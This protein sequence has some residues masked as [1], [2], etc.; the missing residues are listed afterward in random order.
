MNRPAA[1]ARHGFA[2]D[3]GTR[4]TISGSSGAWADVT[5]AAVS[6]AT[7]VT[8]ATHWTGW[9]GTDAF[10]VAALTVDP[11]RPGVAFFGAANQGIWKT[12]DF[13]SSW[14]KVTVGLGSSALDGHT[15]SIAIAGNGNYMLANNGY[16]STGGVYRSTDQ[17]D[18]WTLKVSGD[19]N[20]ITIDETDPNHAIAL[21]H[22]PDDA[23]GN[24]QESFDGGVTWTN[25][26]PQTPGIYGDGRFINR[27]TYICG[28]PTTIGGTTTAGHLFR[29]VRN[30]SNN[31]AWTT[32]PGGTRIDGPHGGTQMFVD[33]VY[34]Y[35][36]IGGVDLNDGGRTKVWRCTLAS[37]GASWTAVC[38]LAG[39]GNY[40]P[41]TIF[42]TQ[43]Y[44]YAQGNYAIHTSY[45]PISHY[46]PRD[47]AGVGNWSNFS[48]DA[49]MTNG[50]HG[51]GAMTD[52]SRW[53]IIGANENAGVW[54]YIE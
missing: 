2:L 34:G 16:G 37:G 24:W 9:S 1:L 30:S 12:E 15:W 42:A 52:G 46:A 10:G 31:F 26:G 48:F 32:D 14:R 49:G 38:D 27:D 13:G 7:N 40:G 20:Y 18:T 28:S 6:L 53:M 4:R 54:R 33:R 11:T 47:N 3:I 36:Y 22:G 8:G 41:A 43:N 19:Y 21:P 51:G 25:I 50:A 45:G 35:M 44:I 5:P 39:A 29:G 23:T 17:G